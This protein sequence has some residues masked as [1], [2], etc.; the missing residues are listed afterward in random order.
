MND[1]DIKLWY[2]SIYN[3]LYLKYSSA[4]DVTELKQYLAN[5]LAAWTPV[6]V[7]YPLATPTTLSVAWQ[8]LS[9]PAWDS[10]IEIVEWSILDLPLYAKYLSTT[11]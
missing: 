8:T 10:R 3:R 7:V 4:T 11:E 2:T 9:I 6:I 5:Q 1:G